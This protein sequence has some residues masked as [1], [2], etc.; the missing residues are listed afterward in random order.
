MISIYTLINKMGADKFFDRGLQVAQAIGL[1][2][3]SWRTGDPT[4][5]MFK[6]LAE[7]LDTL[8]D[9]I[10]EYAKASNLSTAEEGDWLDLHAYDN[11]GV[12]IV[13]ATYATP[14]ITL[15]NPSTNGFVYPL[16]VGDLTVK[17][18]TSGKTYH[19]TALGR[20]VDTDAETLVLA[21]GVTLVFDL[22][23]DEA[24]ADS[25]VG[26]DELDELVTSLEGVEIVSSTAGVAAD[27]PSAEEIKQLCRDSTGALSP[28]GPSDAYEYI[29]RTSK[30]TGSTE[31][32]RASASSDDTRGRVTVYVAG[33]VG[34]VT[35]ASVAL[36]QTAVN[37]WV[38]PLCIRPTVVSAT[39]YPII[40]QAVVSGANIP[41]GYETLVAGVLQKHYASLRI[42]QD[43]ARSKLIAKIH[44]AVP[45][46]ESVTLISPVADVAVGDNGVPTPGALFLERE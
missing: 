43:V 36:A 31:I 12:E 25:T 30:F 1:A 21:P 4:K 22:V 2:V 6:Y 40:V 3:S 35:G 45:Q 16:E 20:D 9:S 38:K 39:N 26:D 10:I 23:A 5:S 24:G 27:K 18:S 28:N 37:K 8:E 33:S 46:I 15:R 32:T 29:C 44:E 34:A 42:G 11:F 19:S 17:S 14:T 13:E 7:C 41:T